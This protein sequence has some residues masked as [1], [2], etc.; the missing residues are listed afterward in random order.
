[1]FYIAYHFAFIIKKITKFFIFFS[2]I[3]SYEDSDVLLF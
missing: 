2:L 3:Y 1:M